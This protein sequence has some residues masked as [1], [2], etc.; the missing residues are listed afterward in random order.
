MDSNLKFEAVKENDLPVI[1]DWFRSPFF[2][3]DTHEPDKIPL[4]EVEFILKFPQA[5]YLLVK[6]ND[7]PIGLLDFILLYE[8][9]SATFELAFSNLRYWNE[10]GEGVLRKFLRLLFL[11]YPIKRAEKWVYEFDIPAKECLKMAGLKKEGIMRSLILKDKKF[12]DIEVYS[13]Y[14]KE[15][16]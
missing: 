15:W 12:Y 5:H 2:Y 9:V 7:E 6:H 13:A 14:E 11:K 10:V 16:R 1:N 3:F 4:R 8:S